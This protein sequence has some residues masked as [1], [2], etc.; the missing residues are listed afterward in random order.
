MIRLLNHYISSRRLALFAIESVVIFLCLQSALLSLYGVR[1]LSFDARHFSLLIFSVLVYE[2]FFYW[3][4]LYGHQ[5]VHRDHRSMM[6]L[7]LAVL[8]ATFVVT[9]L[10][11]VLARLPF[12]PAML[13]NYFLLTGA[14]V[15]VRWL[16]PP[17]LDHT[18][19]LK[20]RILVLGSDADARSLAH[21]IR[22]NAGC[23][24][25]VVGY[26]SLGMP[27]DGP[28]VG[29]DPG[30]GNGHVNGHGPL[31]TAGPIG[32]INTLLNSGLIVA[33]PKSEPEEEWLPAVGTLQELDRIVRDS[34]I[35]TIV[36][37][38]HEDQTRLPLDSLLRLKTQGVL[39]VDV[40]SFYEH[41]KG[42]IPINDPW[43]KWMVFSDGCLPPRGTLAVKR[44]MDVTLS[45]LTLLL[46]LPLFLLIVVCI[47]INSRGPVLF[48]Q[49]RPGL[50]G[51]LFRVYKFR[52][53]YTNADPNRL[54]EGSD[55][56]ITCVGRFL[57]RMRL[58]E[59]PQLFNV[60][61]GDMSLIGPR[62]E[63]L[64]IAQTLE[65]EIPYYSIRHSVK[66]GITG[67]AQIRYGYCASLAELQEKFKYDLFY[68]KNLSLAL[69]LLII[70]ETIKVLIVGKGVR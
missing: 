34:P 35:H 21:E 53:M 38:A 24:I 12:H 44:I 30:N 28:A 41:Y 47:K 49:L 25:H 8:A 23:G 39:V 13:L 52:S 69:D 43:L 9:P 51:R 48:S 29:A 11:S 63:L 62:P 60:L 50:G 10:Y 65:R 14:V 33:P 45:L 54:V 70:L 19:Q 61:K 67:W 16:L 32:N 37:S 66:P 64:S 3:F 31:P 42:Q 40:I 58:D 5:A 4:D 46:A 17:L 26:V 59:L 56:R 2:L 7:V 6:R 68:I 57:R 27:A 15:G 55:A 18:Q 20:H 36:V 22:T 1:L